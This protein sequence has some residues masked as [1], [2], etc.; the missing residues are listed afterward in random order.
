VNPNGNAET[1]YPAHPGNVSA[2]KSGI[3]SRSGR[4]LAPRAAEIADELMSAPH[5]SELDRTGA[6]EIAA[7]ISVI[8]AID[9]DLAKKG[10]G[11]RRSLLDMRLRASGRLERWLAAYG[12]TPQGRATWASTLAHGGLAAEIA[13]RRS[14]TDH[15]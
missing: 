2:V 10:I 11:G 13:R 6:E 12:F 8:D 7:L 3:Y 14:R 1:L 5:L 15:D 4:I 9:A